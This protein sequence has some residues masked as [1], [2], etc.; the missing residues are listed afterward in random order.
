[1]ALALVS[2]QERRAFPIRVAQGVRH[3]AAKAA[4]QAN[5]R[6]KKPHPATETRR[7]GRPQGRQNTA[8][9]DVTLTPA[10]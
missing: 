6:A 5:V 7:L 1:L 2:V 8:K 4:S 9:A 3:D 10:L